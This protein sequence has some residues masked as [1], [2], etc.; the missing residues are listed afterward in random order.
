MF[1]K[2]KKGGINKEAIKASLAPIVP[3][4][5][6]DVSQSQSGQWMII[7][8]LPASEASL[9][10]SIESH[11][12]HSLATIGLKKECYN[13]ALS[14]HK[15]TPEIKKSSPAKSPS[16]IKVSGVKKIIAVA[17]AKGGV[18]K[19]TMAA[20]LA[21]SLAKSGLR[22]GLLDA[23][24]YGPSIPKIFNIEDAKPAQKDNKII[25][26]Q[27]NGIDVMSIGFMVD[28]SQALI[29]RG[30]M[31]QSA[32]KQLLS[33]VNWGYD[34]DLD[35]LILDTPPGTGDVQLTLAQSVQCDGVILVTTPQDLALA[36][37]AKGRAMFEKLN[38]PIL[39]L[40]ENMA[41][42]QCRECNHIDHVFGQHEYDLPVLVSIPL[43]RAN[44][45]LRDEL[46]DPSVIKEILK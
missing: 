17:S 46:F 11:I 6:I 10:D 1:F 38:V 43:A 35:I 8:E 31:V 20:N 40:I 22:V 2:S 28:Q 45:T 30:P 32:F 24:I 16:K 5:L 9:L 14:A 25:P 34:G 39:G 15:A 7:I 36:D 4:A 21:L 23:D 13:I 27:T 19:S 3:T 33:D 29:W 18:G 42:H 44:Q 41:Y 26:I 12:V 37:V